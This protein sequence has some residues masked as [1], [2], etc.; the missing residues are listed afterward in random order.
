M[1]F[2]EHPGLS[3]LSILI[4]ELDVG[5]RLLCGKL[6]LFSTGKC[7]AEQIGTSN[8]FKKRR[9][10]QDNWCFNR[11]NNNFAI[12]SEG[13][14]DK[15]D[16]THFKSVTSSDVHRVKDFILEKP[17]LQSPEIWEKGQELLFTLVTTL[18]TCFP[19]YDFSCVGPEVFVRIE[20]LVS[21]YTTVNYRLSF[22]AERAIPGFLNELWCTIR[23]VVDLRNTMVYSYRNVQGEIESDPHWDNGGCLFSFDYFFVDAKQGRVL[24]FSCMT[25]RKEWNVSDNSNSSSHEQSIITS[26]S[27]DSLKSIKSFETTLSDTDD[28]EDETLYTC[29]IDD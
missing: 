6:E 18:N 4:N 29:P 27:D 15:I 9:T 28:V 21:V 23:D 13:E 17:K 2:L 20:D 5:D 22:F 16:M 24:F 12:T 1:Q 25:K 8:N 10:Y 3:R 11:K 19:D 7:E 26:P 14:E